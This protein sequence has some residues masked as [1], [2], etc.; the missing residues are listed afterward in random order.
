MVIP[1][2]TKA[3][4]R[5]GSLMVELL[6]AMA[7]LAGVAVPLGWSLASER[8]LARS[9]YQR[10]VAMEILDGELEV[11]AAGE[12]RAFSPGTR[13]YQVHARSATNLPPGAFTLTIDSKRVRLE[14]T[15]AIK[16]HGGAISREARFP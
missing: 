15:P 16:H 2:I 12:W 8:T 10:A 14:W 5:R 7:I 13:E 4:R 6:A 9:L 1:R 11:L 3:A